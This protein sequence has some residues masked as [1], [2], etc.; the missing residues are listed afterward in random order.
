MSFLLMCCVV[1]PLL[2]Q[3]ANLFGCSWPAGSNLNEISD[4]GIRRGDKICQCRCIWMA[5]A[6]LRKMRIAGIASWRSPKSAVKPD[7]QASRR[8]KSVLL[9]K[10]VHS[11]F[12]NVV[13]LQ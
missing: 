9:H 4:V 11:G 1:T 8:I 12:V 6:P 3:A 2:W 5:A 13:V 7:P 10:L